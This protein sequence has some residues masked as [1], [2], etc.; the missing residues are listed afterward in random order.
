[1]SRPAVAIIQARM[2]SSRLP[3]KVLRPLAGF[4]MLWHI[5]ERAR[6]CLTVDDVTVAT[7]TEASDDPLAEFCR[8][9]GIPCHRGSLGDVM[10]RFLEVLDGRSNPY[11]VRITGD[12]PL[13]HPPFIDRQVRVLEASEGDMVWIG[14]HTP[15]LEGQG[16]HSVRSLRRAAERSSHPDD[17]EH[18]GSR[19]LAEHPQE[20][21]IIGLRLPG[22]LQDSD[23]RVTVDE[24]P[25]YALIAALYEALWNGRP[26]PL[27]EAVAWLEAHPEVAARNRQVQH[28]LLNQELSEKRERWERY[29]LRQYD[30]EECTGQ[31]PPGIGGRRRA[32]PLRSRGGDQPV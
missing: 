18:V 32:D 10:G 12:C 11:C 26:I 7:S 8:Q 19:Y 27:E 3:G 20:F 28:R 13:I 5:V 31:W 22:W 2:S 4:P 29:V 1:M 21:R 30:W 25:D 23:W 24:Q 6:Q 16:V 17:R 14:A 15:L 9:S